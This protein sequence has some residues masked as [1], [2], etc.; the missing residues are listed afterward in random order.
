MQYRFTTV[1][2]TIALSAVCLSLAACDTKHDEVADAP[3]EAALAVA[4]P[5]RL[6]PGLWVQSGMG[7]GTSEPRCVTSSE[8][9]SANG[10]DD[11]IRSALKAQ[12][13]AEGCSIA[14]TTITGET[15]AFEQ[16]CSGSH[17]LVTTH[18]RGT[19]STTEMTGAGIPAIKSEGRRVGDC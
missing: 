19:S 1:F 6:E 9:L 15:I 8:A 7:G 13:Q 12:S 5:V 16:V 2:S 4:K 3:P 17:I 18:Y 14:S 11:E 10:T